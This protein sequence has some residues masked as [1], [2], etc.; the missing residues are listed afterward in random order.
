M[1]KKNKRLPLLPLLLAALLCLPLALA[2][3]GDDDDDPTVVP[4][5]SGTATDLTM[6]KV[7]G[8]WLRVHSRG[9]ETENGTVTDTWDQ[10][11]EDD[12]DYFVFYTDGRCLRLD[13]D[14]DMRQWEADGQ[15]TFAISSGTATF[16]DG[17]IAGARIVS[18]DGTQMVITYTITEAGDTKEVKQYTDTLRL[19]SRRTDVLSIFDPSTLKPEDLWDDNA[20]SATGLAL[21]D[22]K[23]TWQIVHSKGLELQNGTVSH[24]WDRDAEADNEYFVF[25]ADGRASLMEP[26]EEN[27]TATFFE[28]DG[29]AMFSIQNGQAV[30]QDGTL[31]SMRII[32]CK[33]GEMT[34]HY[35]SDEDKATST[36]E[37][38]TETLRR[39]SERTDFLPTK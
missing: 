34:I 5:P 2:S 36:V 8:T 4:P 35:Q 14:D 13:Y 12:Q 3:C 39:L 33:D 20:P 27:G 23:G 28:S 38:H 9:T 15:A 32:S 24:M 1:E 18:C 25:H 31:R 22:V 17:T 26:K 29:E 11:I 19:T 16:R 6:D 21:E 30:F 37:R 7:S 10:N